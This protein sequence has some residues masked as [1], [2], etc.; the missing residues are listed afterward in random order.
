MMRDVFEILL[1]YLH[2]F[3]TRSYCEVARTL[4]MIGQ[5]CVKQRIKNMQAGKELPNDLLTC[6][7][8]LA[9]K[10]HRVLVSIKLSC[11]F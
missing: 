3:E 1:Q 6:V 9:C 2:P 8:K 11:T 7:L 5:E 4:R 10:W